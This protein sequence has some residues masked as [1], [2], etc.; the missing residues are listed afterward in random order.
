[1]CYEQLSVFDM[2]VGL[3]EIEHTCADSQEED[4][5]ELDSPRVRSPDLVHGPPEG[6]RLV[7]ERFRSQQVVRDN[8]GVGDGVQIVRSRVARIQL[9]TSSAVVERACCA[10]VCSILVARA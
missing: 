6:A 1:M 5:E 7:V 8:V 2:L 10:V 3:M 4:V 9:S